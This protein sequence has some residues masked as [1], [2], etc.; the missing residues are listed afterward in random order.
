[1]PAELVSP[2]YPV[3]EHVVE[4]VKFPPVDSLYPVEL[5]MAWAAPAGKNGPSL[6]IQFS[7]VPRLAPEKVRLCCQSSA[8]CAQSWPTEA[9]GSSGKTESF[10]RTTDVEVLSHLK[11]FE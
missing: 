11:F 2:Q 10:P 8:S 7:T 3:A 1:M 6:W 9:F 4:E 5:T